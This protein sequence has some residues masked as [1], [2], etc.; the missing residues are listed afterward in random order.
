MASPASRDLA[1]FVVMTMPGRRFWCLAIALAL[2]PGHQEPLSAPARKARGHIE[3]TFPANG[4]VVTGPVR[5]RGTYQDVFDL[6]IAF[7]AGFLHEVHTDDPEG[8]DDG[9]WYFDWDPAEH[10]G[11]VEITVRGSSV[12]DLYA[13]WAAPVSVT[14]GPAQD[15]ASIP[16]LHQDGATSSRSKVEAVAAAP[17]VIS[18]VSAATSAPSSP[19]DPAARALWVWETDTQRLLQ[20]P[21]ARQV[22][23]AFMQD[24]TIAP[25]PRRV[26]YLYADRGHSGWVIK[27]NPDLYRSFIG[28]AHAG[29]YS[30][31]A[32][33]GSGSY[34]APMYSYARYHHKAVDLIDAVIAYNAGSPVEARFDGANIDIEPHWLPD[35]HDAPSVQVQYFDMLAA[36]MRRVAESGQKL[37]VGPAIPRWL[38]VS[39]ECR[40]VVWRGDRKTCAQHVQDI[41]DYVALMDYRDIAKT[42]IG[43]I[44]Q[45]AAEIAYGNKVGKPVVIG[46]ETGQ[47]SSGD[48]EA[49]SFY[50]EG[51]DHMES[52]L[53]EVMKA[54]SGE[55]SFGGVAVHHYDSWRRMRTIWSPDGVAWRSPVPDGAAPQAPSALTAVPWDWQRIDLG[56]APASDDV[57][58]DHYEIHRSMTAG[59]TPDVTTLAASTDAEFAKDVGLLAGTTYRYR[60]IAV[61][62]AGKRSTASAEVSATTPVGVGRRRLRIAS[63]SVAPAGVGAVGTMTITDDE[64]RPVEGASVSG[65]FG[66]AAGS[67]FDGVTDSSGTFSAASEG[68]EPPWTVT[69]APERIRARGFYWASSLDVA[70]TSEGSSGGDAGHASE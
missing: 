6:V 43:I 41:T 47:V 66:G 13:R 56:W 16:T 12:V 63:I 25:D 7:D 54:F 35:W 40:S 15:P 23:A 68:L 26:I 9:T 64:G 42:S 17:P 61:D 28:W 34:Q 48:P 11:P 18:A 32:L 8:D 58:V 59:F 1:I 38:D 62:I 52:E 36:M 67:T 69:F 50:E 30:V 10:S 70:H 33:L 44:E 3:V 60:V 4:A 51:R 37:M 27:D 49:I 2:C 29:G 53:A 45:A 5:V 31:H 22:L 46:V 57:M 14:V 55:K 65:R 24:T 19:L 39:D 20:S 21:G